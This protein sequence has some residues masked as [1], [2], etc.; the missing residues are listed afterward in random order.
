LYIPTMGSPAL[1][2]T[3]MDRAIVVIVGDVVEC[4]RTNQNRQYII[5]L[6]NDEITPIKYSLDCK[7]G[8]VKKKKSL[9]V[10]M[11]V[12]GGQKNISLIQVSWSSRRCENMRVRVVR[13]G[14]HESEVSFTSFS[15]ADRESIGNLTAGK[16]DILE[17]FEP[18]ITNP[19]SIMLGISLAD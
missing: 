4:A 7:E 3:M 6:F 12:C 9:Y 17:Q 18:R 15:L 19:R 11:F 8:Q 14:D 16:V 2:I 10:C 5:L 13:G 1:V